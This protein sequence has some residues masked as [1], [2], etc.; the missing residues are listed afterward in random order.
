MSDSPF[1]LATARDWFGFKPGMTRDQA[2]DH[3]DESNLD[4]TE[5]RDDYFSTAADDDVEL[6]FWFATTGDQRMRQLAA[7]GDGVL[8]NG[9]PLTGLRIADALTALEPLDSAPMWDLNDAANNPFPTGE[10][11]PPPAGP[12]SGERLL[13]EATIWLPERGI[14]LVVCDASVLDVVWRAKRDIP[15]KFVGPVTD[16][17]RQLSKRPD[18][19]A[20]LREHRLARLKA[21]AAAKRD[22]L[23]ALRSLWLI[24]C[25]GLLGWVGYL[26]FQEMQRW[27]TARA[28]TGKFVS[29]E[30]VPRKKFFDMAPERFRRHMPDDPIRKRELFHIEYLDPAGRARMA[31]L[32]RA[33]FYVS[34]RNVGEEVQIA[35]VDGDPPQVKGPSRAGDA[36]FLKY[37]PWAILVGAIFVVGEWTFRLLPL[38]LRSAAKSASSKSPVVDPDRPELR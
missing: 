22:P 36:A 24:L 12:I 18:L 32:E 5:N 8:W 37:M 19:E 21:E 27:T 26:G 31:L 7:S 23:S 20:Y 34:P 9:K 25:L 33:D 1:D 6:E 28:L 14:G 30:E 38:L 29:I 3:L 13:E 16:E 11:P 10:V 4:Q 2:Q 17:H 15:K 35:F